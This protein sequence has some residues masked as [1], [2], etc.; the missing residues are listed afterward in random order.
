MTFA[1]IQEWWWHQIVGRIL[2]ILSQY[3]LIPLM[4]LVCLCFIGN[5]CGLNN[6]IIILFHSV[7]LMHNMYKNKQINSQHIIFPTLKGSSTSLWWIVK[8]NVACEWFPISSQYSVVVHCMPWRTQ[9]LFNQFPEPWKAQTGY[10]NWGTNLKERWFVLSSTNV[11]N[12][13]KTLER[14]E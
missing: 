5:A 7:V 1:L 9:M 4:I 13:E 14:G 12:H 2:V 10:P 3:L 6:K 11:W 8:A